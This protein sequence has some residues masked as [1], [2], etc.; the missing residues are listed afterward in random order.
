MV[1][2]LT[3]LVLEQTWFESNRIGDSNGMVDVEVVVVVVVIVIVMVVV[4]VQKW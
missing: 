2:V 4:V 3:V 1:I